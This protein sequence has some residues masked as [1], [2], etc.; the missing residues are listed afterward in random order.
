M[1]FPFRVARG[2]QAL[3][4]AA[5]LVLSVSVADP[6][7]AYDVGASDTEIR[8]G[9]TQPYSGPASAL[10]GIGK[11]ELRYFK[12]INDNGG[13]NGRKI[14]LISYDDGYSPPKAVEHVRKLVESDEV[15]LIFQMNG[16]PS[17]A[18]VQKYLNAKKIPQLL[19][20]TGTRRFFSR[21][22]FP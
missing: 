9:Q 3:A 10:S 19:S 21:K 13:I 4:S 12:M 5:V 11:T 6:Q 14:T 16:T 15:L 2:L 7:K 8:L 20:A 1:S 17:N 22:E 18:A